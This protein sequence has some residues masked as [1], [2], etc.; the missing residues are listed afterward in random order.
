MEFDF[1]YELNFPDGANSIAAYLGNQKVDEIQG[2]IKL[3]GYA[4]E[5]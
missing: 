2:K 5:E 1:S 3:G 4:I